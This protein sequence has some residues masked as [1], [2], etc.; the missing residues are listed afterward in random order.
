MNTSKKI[1]VERRCETVRNRYTLLSL[2]SLALALLTG[3]VSAQQ[4]AADEDKE[5]DKDAIEEIVVTGIRGALSQALDAKR[6]S[7]SILDAINAEDIGKFPDQNAAES[8]SRVAGVS[9]TRDFGEGERISIRGTRSSQNRSLLNGMP[10]ATTEWFTLNLSS[11]GFNYT[12]LPANLVKSIKVY[13]TPQAD[14]Q[15]GSLGGTVVMETNKPLELKPFTLSVQGQGQYSGNSEKWN[16]NGSGLFSWHNDQQTLGA[17]ISASRQARAVHRYGREV[18][19]FL[20]PG[21]PHNSSDD[22][23]APRLMSLADFRQE[24]E[25]DTLF[26]SGQWRPG[27]RFEMTVNYLDTVL[28]ADSNNNGNLVTIN[29]GDRGTLDPDSI[30]TR[31]SGDEE[32]VVAGTWYLRNCVPTP[33]CNSALGSDRNGDG[34]PDNNQ[35]WPFPGGRTQVFDRLSRIDTEALDLE[36]TYA[37]DAGWTLSTHIGD[38]QSQGGAFDQRGWFFSAEHGGYTWVD[39]NT[40]EEIRRT[41][42]DW[43]HAATLDQDLNLRYLTTPE[44]KNGLHPGGIDGLRDESDQSY[45]GRLFDYGNQGRSSTVDYEEEQ[46][47]TLDFEQNLNNY[48]LTS[49]K[50]GIMYRDRDKGRDYHQYSY[51][52]NLDEDFQRGENGDFARDANGRAILRAGANANDWLQI[53]PGIPFNRGRHFGSD[54]SVLTI[55]HFTNGERSPLGYLLVDSDT[56]RALDNRP[57]EALLETIFLSDTWNV[58][59]EVTS[60]YVKADYQLDRVRGE[61]G[62]R[63]SRTTTNSQ[64]YQVVGDPVGAALFL[65]PNAQAEASNVVNRGNNRRLCTPDTCYANWITHSNSY[66]EFLPN[67]NLSYDLNSEVVLR[68]GAARVMARPDPQALAVRTSYY[69]NINAGTRGNPEMEAIIANQYDLSAE[70]YF[71]EESLLAMTLFYKDISGSPL[72]VTGKETRTIFENGEQVEREFDITLPVNGE[73]QRLFGMEALWQ[74]PLWRRFGALFN[75]TWTNADVPG[76]ERSPVQDQT[77]EFFVGTGLG[78]GIVEG[79][80]EHTLNG[81]FYYEHANLNARISYNWRSEYLSETSYFGSETWTDDYG[82]LTFTTSYKINERIDLVGQFINITDEDVDQYH[83]IPARRSK[84]YDNDRRFVVIVNV[85]F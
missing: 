44:G 52:R 36:F 13:K 18:I 68:F 19:R 31:G 32:G 2:V 59:E 9:V 5:V 65:N 27:D 30:V 16:Q 84:V 50:A 79:A 7:A 41:R 75:Y 38:T 64:G 63:I 40:G 57:T 46:Y 55:A 6:D 45:A 39:P 61:L 10:I 81:S 54:P 80:S 15:E 29:E 28:D 58:G 25:R 47:L 82:Y 60:A 24:R 34:F 72:S 23:W 53:T 78:S 22:Y 85:R 42:D 14:I 49:F 26:F 51:V 3:A 12:V 8:L 56:A 66:T 74:Q 69:S 48:A 76:Q 37:S 17:L 33:G 71:A 43:I 67:F 35:P 70:W 83:L 20:E 73:N 4:P 11:R 1:P 77:G 21:H 62:L